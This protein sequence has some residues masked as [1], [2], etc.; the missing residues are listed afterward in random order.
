[1]NINEEMLLK[2]AK[3]NSDNKFAKALTIYIP[4]L[5][6]ACQAKARADIQIEE[7]ECGPFSEEN[8]PSSYCEGETYKHHVMKDLL[9]LDRKYD[10]T[11]MYNELRVVQENQNDDM[12]KRVAE[13]YIPDDETLVEFT[14]SCGVKIITIVASWCNKY[15]EE[16]S[17][18][19]GNT[20]YEAFQ[21]TGFLEGLFEQ[22]DEYFEDGWFDAE[23]SD[24]EMNIFQQMRKDFTKRPV[25]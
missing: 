15:T 19:V 4:A 1:M 6:K 7:E 13:S 9:G 20:W 10:V 5:Q 22:D 14:E 18:Y 11:R 21:K 24:E 17:V 2:E 23:L 16:V 3:E 8:R 12:W 25:C